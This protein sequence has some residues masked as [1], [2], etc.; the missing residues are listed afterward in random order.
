M[1][2]STRSAS[3]IA[4]FK[5]ARKK[6]D[7]AR[8]DVCSWEP[9][10]VLEWVRKGCVK[11]LLHAHHCI[12]LALGGADDDSNLVLLCP[13]CHALADD[14]GSHA[15][16]LSHRPLDVIESLRLLIAEPLSWKARIIAENQTIVKLRPR[17]TLAELF[18]RSGAE[19]D[20]AIRAFATN[21][22]TRKAGVSRNA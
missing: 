13:T 17:D 21:S 9:P 16:A 4:Q 5:K 3:V 15:A 18:A 22:A 6:S 1:S 19:T 11:N 7:S 8:C 14:I 2:L 20:A 10:A 12:P